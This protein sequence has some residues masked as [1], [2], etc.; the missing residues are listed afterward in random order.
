MHSS[1]F[2]HTPWPHAAKTEDEFI[3]VIEGTP[4]VWLDG[5]LHGLHDT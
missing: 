3:C 2:R 1:P 5:A 4:Y